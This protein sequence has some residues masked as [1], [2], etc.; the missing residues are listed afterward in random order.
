MTFELSVPKPVLTQSSG[1]HLDANQTRRHLS[2]TPPFPQLAGSGVRRGVPTTRSTLLH[3]CVCT[4]PLQ[5][6]PPPGTERAPRGQGLRLLHLLT[7]HG[8]RP[9]RGGRAAAAHA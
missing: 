5:G 9:G 2:W 7:L 3:A 1:A 4:A 6:S 8:A